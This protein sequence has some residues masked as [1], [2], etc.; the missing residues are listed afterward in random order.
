MTTSSLILDSVAPSLPLLLVTHHEVDKGQAFNKLKKQFGWAC[1]VVAAGDDQN[2][3]PLLK[4][5]DIKIVM[6]NAPAGVRSLA[7]IIAKTSFER[8]IIPALE[9]CKKRL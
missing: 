3:I 6:S 2:D 1:P 7:D 5:A 4:I 9:E 8:G